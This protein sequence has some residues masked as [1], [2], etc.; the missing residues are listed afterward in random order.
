MKKV[1]LTGGIASGKSTVSKHLQKAGFP[2]IDADQVAREIVEVGT[3]ALQEI[4]DAFGQH[5]Q[6]SDG[7]LNRKALGHIIFTDPQ[8]RERLNQITHPRIA[9]RTLEYMQQ[10]QKQET[11]ILIYEAPLLIENHIHE[12]MDEVLLISLSEET[13]IQRL[14]MR[15]ALTQEEALT[16]IRSQMSLAEK[17]KYATYIIQNEG[18]ENDLLEE[19]KKWIQYIRKNDS[20]SHIKTI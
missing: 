12:Q 17:K 1:G 2:V 13:Q 8:K 18:D 19:I 14:C 10:H 9:Q 4:F 16:R 6:E 15:E 20:R 5:L 11:P 7:S 3:P